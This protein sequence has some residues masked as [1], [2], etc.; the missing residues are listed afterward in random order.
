MKVGKI[1]FSNCEPVYYGFHAGI[2]PQPFDLVSATPAGLAEMLKC[3]ELDV[4]PVSTTEYLANRD[5]WELLPGLCIATLGAVESVLLFSRLPFNDLDGRLV[6]LSTKSRTSNTLVGPLLRDL[7]GARPHFRLPGSREEAA[8][9]LAIGDE[10]LMAR[11]HADFPYVLDLGEAWERLTGKS[12]VF[13][14]WVARRVRLIHDAA[15]CRKIHHLLLESKRL[16]KLN[17]AAVAAYAHGMARQK[18]PEECTRYLGLLRFDL[19]ALD[20]AGLAE[21]ERYLVAEGVLPARGVARVEVARH[22]C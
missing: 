15:A 7:H 20:L 4:S 8:A 22:V 9:F 2:L 18:D 10:A 3:N 14:V 12:L 21:M 17:L 13:A 1:A 11:G 5:E 6:H 16:G 19:N